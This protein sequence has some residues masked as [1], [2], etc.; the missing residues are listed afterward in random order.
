MSSAPRP[1]APENPYDLSHAPTTVLLG[2][3]EEF[4]LQTDPERFRQ[5]ARRAGAPSLLAQAW[6]ET[7]ELAP[8]EPGPEA[9]LSAV[10]WELWRRWTP[11]LEAAELLAEEFD[12]TFEPLDTLL[13]G[14][15]SLLTE[16]L[17]R[18]ERLLEACAPPGEEPDR[19]LFE[20]IWSHCWHDLA[21]WLR[22]LPLLLAERERFDDAI[23]LCDRLAPL[24]E[25]RP[26]LAEKGLLLARAGR[27][28]E[29][30][31]QVRANLRRWPGDPT[32]LRKACE[33]LWALGHAE[34]ALLLYD[35]VLEL[36]HAASARR[37]TT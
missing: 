14:P 18:A 33:T 5:E 16:A 35:D 19:D 1:R 32:I 28:A 3:L 26:I 15:P 21:A 37:G 23:R 2:R 27:S 31:R 36:T 6:I 13:F 17:A 10:A 25:A 34:E 20:S 7:A 11:D 4:G 9:T 30:R 8:G 29:A 22:C 24:F 12:R